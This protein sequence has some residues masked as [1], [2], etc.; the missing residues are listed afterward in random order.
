MDEPAIATFW[1]SHPCGDAQV[2]G[3]NETY[4]GDYEG[5][6]KDYD[7]FRYR[8]EPH[9]LACLDRLAVSGKRLL[10][11]GIGEGAEAEQLVLRGARYSALDLTPAAVDRTTTRLTL[12]GLPFD[13]IERASVLSVPWPDNSFDMV[14]SHGVLHHVP[15]IRQAQSEIRRVLRPD[16]E[17]VVMLYYRWSLNYLV[18]I[19]LLRR[20]AVVA[21]YPGR[22]R[23][24]GG[25]L[26]E[27]VLNAEKYGLLRYLRMGNFVHANTDGPANPY[28]KV[29]DLRRVREDFADFEVVDS[30]RTFM[31]APPLPVH[32]LPGGNVAG[33]H[34]WVR[35]RPR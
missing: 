2:G 11:V 6:F 3:L 25:L 24:R 12:R 28:S 1:N 35:L 5:F 8:Y 13:R 4:R 10:E 7:E 26:R 14:F 31:H 22:R 30:W 17:L 27:H 23:I 33:W 19:G 9:I 21:A 34:L 15:E 16:G 32:G 29:Y 18:A 20:L